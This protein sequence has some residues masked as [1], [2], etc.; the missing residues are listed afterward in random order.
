MSGCA[1]GGDDE[2]AS[3]SDAA[4][5][6]TSGGASEGGTDASAGS[7][8]A[9][10]VEAPDLANRP[11][12]AHTSEFQTEEAGCTGSVTMYSDEDWVVWPEGGQQINLESP[13]GVA[14]AARV[15]AYCNSRV[16]SEEASETP[17]EWSLDT[18]N[19][20]LCLETDE[21]AIAGYDAIACLME[22]EDGN[23][24]YTLYAMNDEVL[25]LVTSSI[26]RNLTDDSAIGGSR[27]QVQLLID[28]TVTLFEYAEIDATAV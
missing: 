7:E 2:A 3:T 21:Y 12:T 26:M 8:D 17:V 1:S 6:E 27:E 10:E 19:K 4:A 16:A 24:G 14:W 5:A 25:V 20:D 22:H 13:D 11:D 28:E 23:F 18:I 15:N 9:S